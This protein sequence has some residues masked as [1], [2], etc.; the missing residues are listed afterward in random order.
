MS[1]LIAADEKLRYQALPLDESL[2]DRLIEAQENNKIVVILTDSWSLQVDRYCKLMKQFDARNFLNCTVLIPWNLQDDE[3]V[4]NLEKL[5]ALVKY[6]FPTNVI[7]NNPS[8]FF[9]SIKTLADFKK[10]LSTSL[11]KTRMRIIEY[12]DVRKKAEGGK[13][14]R[15]IAVLC[16]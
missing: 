4:K 7:S 12:A 3:T 6:A 13:L 16:G 1:S 15:S 2:L 10:Q 9:D 8:Y 11:N 5:E 14:I